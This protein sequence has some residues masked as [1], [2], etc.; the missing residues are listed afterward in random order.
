MYYLDSSAI[1]SNVH[2]IELSPDMA[3]YHQMKL[4]EKMALGEAAAG[5]TC[6]QHL[7]FTLKE[8]ALS[9]CFFVSPRKK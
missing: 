1:E 5:P 3:K 7:V 2:L 8:V 9:A 4:E 6:I